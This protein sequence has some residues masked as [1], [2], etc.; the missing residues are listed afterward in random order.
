MGAAQSLPSPLKRRKDSPSPGGASDRAVTPRHLKSIVPRKG[1]RSRTLTSSRGAPEGDIVI[2]PTKVDTDPDAAAADAPQTRLQESLARGGSTVAPGFPSGGAAPIG[3]RLPIVAGAAAAE[4]GG[5]DVDEGGDVARAFSFMNASRKRKQVDD[6]E[7]VHAD[8]GADDE[9]AAPGEEEEA[10]GVVPPLEV[11]APEG[12]RE[13]VASDIATIANSDLARDENGLDDHPTIDDKAPGVDG[14]AAAAGGAAIVAGTALV[15]YGGKK[16]AAAEDE[17]TAV[18]SPEGP[19]DGEEDP[20]LFGAFMDVIKHPEGAAGARAGDV[21]FGAVE[22][23]TNDVELTFLD[24]VV[25]SHDAKG[26]PDAGSVLVRF[27]GGTGA[28]L[29]GLFGVAVGGSM[30]CG[31]LVAT[32]VAS[33]YFKIIQFFLRQLAL[34]L[35]GMHVISSFL[36]AIIHIAV[37]GTPSSKRRAGPGAE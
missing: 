12:E 19:Q 6:E 35:H 7:E 30:G 37:D 14:A 2:A 18:G 34:L 24:V 31:V 17:A 15:A 5:E 8:A 36:A 25:A 26:S 9:G 11:D 21:D 16:D 13:E 1:E 20:S 32:T 3:A 27:M 33:F 10:P 4:R 28:L 29:G 23:D 22:E